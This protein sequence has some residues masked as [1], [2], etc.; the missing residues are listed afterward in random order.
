MQNW[1]AKPPVNYHVTVE[2]IGA[3]TTENRSTARCE[4][5]KKPNPKGIGV[6]DEEIWSLKIQRADFHGGWNYSFAHSNPT[7]KAVDS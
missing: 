5:D 2:R 3:T 6:L 1:R 4:P 7:I